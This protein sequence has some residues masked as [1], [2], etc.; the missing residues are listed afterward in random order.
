MAGVILQ[1]PLMFLSRC[2]AIR[3]SLPG[4]AFCNIDKVSSINSPVFIIHGTHDEVVPFPMDRNF[5]LHFKKNSKYR[6]FWVDNAGHNN[7][8]LL[9]AKTMN[10]SI[11]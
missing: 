5:T 6:P 3:F 9:A 11:V 1:S 8:E 7:I 2:A 10:F 4:D